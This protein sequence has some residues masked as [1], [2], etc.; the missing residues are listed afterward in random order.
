MSADDILQDVFV[1]IHA[2][3][4]QL[5]AAQKLSSWVFRITHN[6]IID[7]Y[8]QRKAVPLNYDEVAIVDDNM[9]TNDAAIQL[10]RSLRGM[11]AAL[12]ENYRKTFDLTVFQGQT[13]ESAAVEL[14][15]S[16]SAVKS[17]VRRGRKLLKAM[18]EECCHIELDRRGTVIDY[19]P[20]QECR[21]CQ[22]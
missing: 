5:H 4:G 13:Q 1:K 15:V 12:P 20:V 2:N 21:C 7:H 18:F 10:S 3:I 11:I 6:A 9:V 16:V 17:R 19:H 22:P 14:G 8:R